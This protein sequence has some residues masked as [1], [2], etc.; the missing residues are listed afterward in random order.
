MLTSTGRWAA[1]NCDHVPASCHTT[2]DRIEF[3]RKLAHARAELTSNVL[4][5]VVDIF[6]KAN[7]ENR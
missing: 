2:F 6:G 7:R 3:F 4:Q 5:F 1:V